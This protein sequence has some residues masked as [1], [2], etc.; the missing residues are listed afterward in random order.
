MMKIKNSFLNLSFKKV[1]KIHKVVNKKKNDKLKPKISII[2]KEPS[3]RQVLISISPE[4]SKKFIVLSGQHI[5]NI[6][7]VLKT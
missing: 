3:Q 5:I 2:T 4:N 6:N 1:E 7:R